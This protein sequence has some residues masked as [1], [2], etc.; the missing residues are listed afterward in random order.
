MS[1]ETKNTADEEMN[2]VGENNTAGAETTAKT[3]TERFEDLLKSDGKLQGEFDR[4][5]QKAIE[6]AKGKWEQNLTVEQDEAKKLEKMTQAQRDSYL[7]R[8][9]KA[10][11]EKQ[12]KAF[13]SEQM[14]VATGRELMKRGFD[15]SFAD[16]LT[17][18]TAEQTS[19]NI[20][21]FEEAFKA[22]VQKSTNDK[23]R[24]DK[25]PRESEKKTAEDDAFLRGFTAKN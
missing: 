21:A 4:R 8:K 23:M 6:T 13:L 1:E 19:R 11:F 7:L 25:P 12:K 3:D 14:K 9:E 15:A 10:E 17:S 16:F 5:I 20:S 24:G 2:T 18:D 22:A